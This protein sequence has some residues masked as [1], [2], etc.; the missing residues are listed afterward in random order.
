MNPPCVELRNVRFTYASA[1]QTFRA[2]KGVSCCIEEGE[3][4]AIVGPSGSGKSTLLNI[5]GLLSRPTEGEMFISGKPLSSFNEDELAELRNT[6]LGFVFQSF[7]LVA[8]LNVLENILLPLTFSRDGGSEVS[9]K[10]HARAHEL[11]GR[12]HL[13]GLALRYPSELSGGQKQRVAICR[14][15]VMDPKIIL[16]DEPTGALDSINSREVLAALRQLHAE[17]RTIVLITHDADIASAAQRTILIR[18]GRDVS[19]PEKISDAEP[20]LPP[21]IELPTVEGRQETHLNKWNQR[22]WVF[23]QSL[24][25]AGRSLKTHRLRSALTG[26]G[27][28]IGILSLIVIDGLGEIVGNAFNKLFFTS[29][30]RKAYIY[31]DDGEGRFHGRRSSQWRG[32]H[33]QEEFPKFAKNFEKKGIVRPFLRTSTCQIKTETGEFRSRLV[34]V[35]D[36]EEF[37]EMEAPLSVGR[38]PTSGEFFGGTPVAVLGSDTVEVLFDKRDPRRREPSFPV[39]TRLTADNCNTLGTFTV[40]GVMKKRDTSFGNRDANDVIYSP[41]QAL[42][43]RMG[44]TFYTWFSV[45]PHADVDTKHLT[46]ELTTYLSLQSGGRLSF[47]SSVPA[48]MLD[49]V[50]GFLRI[51]QAIVGFI[52]G[53]CLFVGGIGIMNMMLVTVA[54]RT[55]EIGLLKSLGARQAHVRSYILTEAILLS[56]FAGCTALIFGFFV[57][58]GFSLAVSWTVPLLKEFRWVIAPWGLIA[59]ALVSVLCGVGFGAL[60]ASRAAAMD[61]ADCLRSE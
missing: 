2:L 37:L 43:N 31:L 20:S 40:I 51:I 28:F 13:D 58:N 6:S 33:A 7:S 32:L 10:Y 35:S 1:G 47:A 41:N 34:G 21:A 57:N 14:A 27:L 24:T 18:D 3:F 45:L 52:G 54:E 8:R 19:S 38:F 59:G 53:L 39:G 48:D 22:L 25:L 26:V 12:F 46:R 16:A 44:P 23:R 61:P 49:R 60:P 4:V 9:A 15:L 56:S 30:V 55:R 42:L 17:G 36:P 29:S 50:R 5:I 11:L